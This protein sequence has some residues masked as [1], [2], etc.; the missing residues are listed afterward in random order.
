MP[1]FILT[2][3][4]MNTFSWVVSYPPQPAIINTTL[5]LVMMGEALRLHDFTAAIAC[6][7]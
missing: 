2:I 5:A 3:L 1:T 7:L 4:R 6:L